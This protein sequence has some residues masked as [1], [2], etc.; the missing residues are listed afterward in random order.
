MFKTILH[1]GLVAV[2]I[3]CPYVCP[4][5]CANDDS[6]S[7]RLAV[8]H[9]CCEHCPARPGDEPLSPSG[10]CTRDCLCKGAVSQPKVQLDFAADCAAW[11]ACLVLADSCG[12]LEAEAVVRQDDDVSPPSGRALR[13]LLAALTC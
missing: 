11:T 10:K 12:A 13:T 9:S 6:V 2:L 3:G 7:G 1:L 8:G 4:R 5:C